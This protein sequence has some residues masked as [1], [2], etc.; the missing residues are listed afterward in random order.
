[1]GGA[2][3]VFSS[4]VVDIGDVGVLLEAADEARHEAICALLGALPTISRPAGVAIRYLIHAPALPRREPDHD[5]DGYRIWYQNDTL[6]LAHQTGG[7]ARVDESTGWI[8][9]GGDGA[10][11]AFRATFHLVVTHLL[12]T[13]D[14]FVLHAGAVAGADGAYLVFGE[15]GAGKSTLSLAALESGWRVLSDDMVVLRQTGATV[16]VAG[17]PRPVAVP[18]DLRPTSFPPTWPDGRGRV[19]LSPSCLSR[20]WAP[21]TG[22]IAVGHGSSPEGALRALAGHRALQVALRSFASTMHPPLLRRFF[23][24]AAALARRPAWELLHGSDTSGRLDVA[25]RLLT[26]AE[27]PTATLPNRAGTA[28]SRRRPV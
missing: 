11:A 27:T 18:H 7:Q 25:S 20:D 5:L 23:P 6:Y 19:E 28:A 13:K 2:D 10:V 3:A 12:A 26:A 15:S 17:I 16:Q 4:R 24:A 14:R 1:M 8:G 21:V 22:T 9:G